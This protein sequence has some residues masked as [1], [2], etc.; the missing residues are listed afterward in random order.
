MRSAKA[1]IDELGGDSRCKD[2]DRA[3][4]VGHR[5]GV[6]GT[7]TI[8]EHSWDDAAEDGYGVEDGEDVWRE[9][10]SNAE[11][12]GAGLNVEDGAEEGKV[13]DTVGE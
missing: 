4:E 12:D 6:H 3:Q 5:P 8:R 2:H 7:Y 9:A 1:G 11:G 13:A 10:R